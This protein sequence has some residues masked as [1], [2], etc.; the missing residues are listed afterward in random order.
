M[1][2]TSGRERVK[3][4][5]QYFRV[6]LVSAYLVSVCKHALRSLCRL[7][8]PRP[9]FDKRRP[10]GRGME[11]HIMHNSTRIINMMIVTTPKE[12]E[13][14]EEETNKQPIH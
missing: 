5:F 11:A 10:K 4:V 12:E 2:P 9:P 14:E 8:I 3:D 13:E 7:K 6:R 1:D